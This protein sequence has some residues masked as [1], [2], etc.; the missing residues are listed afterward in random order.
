[1]NPLLND[2]D[3][4]YAAWRQ[5]LR[6]N[7]HLH[8]PEAA[9]RLQVPEAALLASANGRGGTQL[10]TELGLL[11]APVADWGRVLVASRNGIG[12]KLDVLGQAQIEPVSDGLRLHDALHDLWLDG[13]GIACLHLFEEEDG[14]G[15]TLSL[16]WFDGQGQVL[17]RLFLMS[18]SGREAALPHLLGFAVDAQGR[19]WQASELSAPAATA[20]PDA[21]TQALPGAAP[22]WASAAILSCDAVPQMSL[23]LSGPGA[24][25]HYRGSLGKCSST[26]PAVHATDL[27]CKLHAR[28]AGA[29][30]A[31]RLAEGGIALLDD[32]G[33]ELRL[34][35]L[36]D[37][38][39]WWARVKQHMN[40]EVS[41]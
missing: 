28:A 12:V 24:R 2:P 37:P 35:P 6:D 11:L 4:L 41:T 33:G 25:S 20:L 18:K 27:L 1:M 38:A 39:A 21:A 15:R 7:P 30:S 3:A 5:A 31:L 26:P 14:H 19:R 32:A 22:L 23:Q 8:G 16:N 10:H 40:G 29:R 36:Q 34:Q 13:R 17:G 9:A